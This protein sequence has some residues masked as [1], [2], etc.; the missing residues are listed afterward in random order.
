MILRVCDNGNEQIE[1]ASPE[2]VEQV[3]APDAPI[4]QGTEITVAEGERWL[5]AMAVGAAGT[6]AELL[7][8]GAEGETATVS[9]IAARS[10][11]LRLFREFLASTGSLR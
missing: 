2:R 5:T 11:A 8:S 1:P 9:G 10:E 4:A 3:F 7:L 6:P